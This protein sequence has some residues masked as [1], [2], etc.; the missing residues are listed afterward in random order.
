MKPKTP[1]GGWTQ[2]VP[3]EIVDMAAVSLQK[4]PVPDSTATVLALTVQGT[5]GGTGV[6]PG[7][8]KVRRP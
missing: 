5:N 7:N 4:V 3:Q 2:Q 1:S 8:P 6:E